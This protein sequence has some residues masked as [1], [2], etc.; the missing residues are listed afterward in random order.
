MK[1]NKTP[2]GSAAAL[3]SSANDTDEINDWANNI[4]I[5]PQDEVAAKSYPATLAPG[6]SYPDKIFRAR[7]AAQPHLFGADGDLAA[8]AVETR[9][10][11]CG[12]E[13]GVARKLIRDAEKQLRI[14]S[15]NKRHADKHLRQLSRRGKTDT[16][17][18]YSVLG[19]ML[20]G[21]G[22]GVSQP[23]INYGEVP[24]LAI[25][26]SL[27]ASAT[28][29]VSGFSGRALKDHHRARQRETDAKDLKPELERYSYRF[30]DLGKRPTAALVGAGVVATLVPLGIGI[31]R[32]AIDGALFG[33]VFGLIGVG[34]SVASFL[35]NYWYTDDIADLLAD[36]DKQYEKA[37]SRLK[38]MSQ[39]S[40]IK[41]EAG[42]LKTAESIKSEQERRGLGATHEMEALGEVVKQNNGHIFGHGEAVPVDAQGTFFTPADLVDLAPHLNGHS[43]G[44]SNGK[45]AQS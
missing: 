11:T 35:A 12:A 8:R 26:Q 40:A 36:Y 41:S 30:R 14:A 21:D 19:L 16:L 32:T 6:E 23:L 33:L 45:V 25:V 39:D 15:K 17:I 18:Y 31:L 20:A 9:A 22:T 28:M 37:T 4:Y 34:V 42:A 29:V 44:R 3:R 7:K 38:A 24:M 2:G 10:A 43:N 27:S 13:A 1:V 5:Q